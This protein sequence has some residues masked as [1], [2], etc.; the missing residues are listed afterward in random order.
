MADSDALYDNKRSPK[1]KKGDRRMIG[2]KQYQSEGTGADQSEE[3]MK[4]PPT[5]MRDGHYW[6]PVPDEEKPTA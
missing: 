5:L 3:D 1:W 2:G 4:K 6:T